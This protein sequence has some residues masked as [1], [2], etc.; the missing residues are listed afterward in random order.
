MDHQYL[1]HCRTYGLA[2]D[3]FGYEIS[4]AFFDGIDCFWVRRAANFYRGVLGQ[5]YAYDNGQ[6]G[7]LVTCFEARFVSSISTPWAEKTGKRCVVFLHN[8]NL[9]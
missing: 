6:K 2:V 1:V 4:I 3:R 5:G 7:R 8:Q 9:D